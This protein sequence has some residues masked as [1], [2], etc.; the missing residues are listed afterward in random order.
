MERTFSAA[1]VWADDALQAELAEILKASLLGTRVDHTTRASLA[2]ENCIRAALKIHGID[3]VPVPR[4]AAQEKVTGIVRRDQTT[5]T[6]RGL[7]IPEGSA[8][9][10]G[11][12]PART[13]IV[14]VNAADLGAEAQAVASLAR[15]CADP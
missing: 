10:R 12:A 6:I 2:E 11:D 13:G 3:V 15:R 1:D 7:R 14:A 8:R 4:N 9:I 5:N